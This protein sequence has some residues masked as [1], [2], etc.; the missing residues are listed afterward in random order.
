MK[1]I[2]ILG[3]TGSVGR[4]TLRV[5]RHLKGEI[6]VAALAARSN[7]DLLM[8][9][10]EEFRPALVAIWD[11]V[12]A[13]E[14][15]LR[16]PAIEVMSGAE[17]IAAAAAHSE[18]DLTV[19]AM[20]G[21][22]AL[23]SVAL[24][25]E[26]GKSIAL[27]NKEVLVCAGEWIMGLAKRRKT[28]VLPIDSEHS[29]IFQCLQGND[30]KTVRRLILT[31]SGGPFRDASLETL[32]SANVESALAHPNWKMGKK[33]SIDSSTLMNKGL[34]M[35]EAKWLF[36]I[37]ASRIQTIVH[38]QS[39][40]H[41]MVEYCDGSILAQMGEPDMAMPIQYAL[42][43]PRRLE[44]MFEPFD[45]LR[46]SQ[47]TFREPDRKKFPCLKLAEES[48]KLGRSFPCALNAANDVFVEQFLQGRCRWGEIAE[49]LEKLM[50]SHAASDLLSLEAVLAVD[51]ETRRK[52]EEL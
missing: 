4:N 7:I 36:D 24:A 1:R 43:Y 21:N 38:P 48:L 10:A 11:P 40:V 34:E 39:I 51:F 16:F 20:S 26:A 47:L 19:F 27:A 28:T 31:A 15:K 18:V 3:S 45:F 50:S 14:F 22:A 6:R 5:A 33:I 9:Q 37:P 32:Q 23:A 46:N 41:S 44:G 2:A 29:A 13:A 49:K 52:A 35:I 8:E 30:S 17:G 12:K 25:I 42:T